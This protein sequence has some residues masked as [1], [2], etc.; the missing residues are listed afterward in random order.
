MKGTSA[1]SRIHAKTGTLEHDHAISGY[2]STLQGEHL[3]FAIFCNN[4][5]Q[6]GHEAVATLDEISVAM[7]ETLGAPASK[8]KKK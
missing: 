3:V 2:A 6:R 4:N 5:P 7:V 1:A 8:N